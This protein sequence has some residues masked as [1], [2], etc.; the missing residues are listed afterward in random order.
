MNRLSLFGTFVLLSALACADDGSGSGCACGGDYQYPR[1]LAEAAPTESSARARITVSG[2]DAIGR[3]VPTILAA[4]CTPEGEDASSSCE[5]SSDD[6][7]IA[8]LYL[9]SPGA[10]LQ[11]TTNLLLTSIVAE[12]RSGECDGQP[13]HRSNLGLHLDS[14]EGNVHFTLINDEQGPGIEMIFGCPESSISACT[15][16]QFKALA[17]H[18]LAIDRFGPK[19]LVAL[20]MTQMRTRALSLNP[21]ASCF[22]PTLSW[23]RICD[24]SD[25]GSR[26]DERRRYQS[27]FQHPPGERHR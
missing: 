3:S 17:R 6:P 25:H 15:E 7:N 1:D 2:L 4:G 23:V 26:Y 24:L 16:D 20:S 21:H 19:M 10:P 11:S 13:C 22:G 18:G 9:G 12:V 8:K 5:L 14:L 27:R